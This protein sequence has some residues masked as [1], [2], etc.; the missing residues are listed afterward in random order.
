MKWLFL[1][2]IFIVCFAGYRPPISD[3]AKYDIEKP[4]D[5]TRAK[6]DIAT[7]ESEKADLTEQ[8]KAGAKMFVP[9]AAARAILHRD[10]QERAEVATGEYNQAIDNKIKEIKEKCGNCD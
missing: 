8:A 1:V 4:I 10:Y 7:L 3:E 5:C 2:Y 6:E 9:A